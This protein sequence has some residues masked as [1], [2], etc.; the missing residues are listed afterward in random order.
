MKGFLQI[1][2]WILGLVILTTAASALS[3]SNTKRISSS[4]CPEAELKA[5]NE[6]NNLVKNDFLGRDYYEVMASADGPCFLA[7][8]NTEEQVLLLANDPMSGWSGFYEVSPSQLEKICADRIRYEDFHNHFKPL[9]S[10]HLVEF[11]TRFGL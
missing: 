6:L 5:L 11:P 1:I 9:P 8:Y 3:N 7:N 4:D 2:V 10:R